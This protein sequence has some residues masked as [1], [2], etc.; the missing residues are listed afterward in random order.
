[1]ELEATPRQSIERAAAAPVERQE[2]ARFAGCRAGGRHGSAGRILTTHV[3]SLIRPPKLQEFLKVQRDK[4]PYDQAAFDACLHDAVADVVRKQAEI[5]LDVINDGEYGKTIS[6]SRYVLERMSGF[7][8]R[9]R[10]AHAGMPAAVAGR[11]RR[12]FANSTPTTT[13]IRDLPA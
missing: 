12:E 11:D 4:E 10:P 6:W 7:E 1:M 3:G 9:D 5:G 13:G 2:A 8:Q